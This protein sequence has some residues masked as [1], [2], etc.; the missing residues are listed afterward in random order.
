MNANMA[1][2]A[3]REQQRLRYRVLA[4]S[5][6]MSQTMSQW[7]HRTCTIHG[8]LNAPTDAAQTSYSRSTTATRPGHPI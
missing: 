2:D 6:T 4:T 8:L 5:Q 1:T 7:C 3:T